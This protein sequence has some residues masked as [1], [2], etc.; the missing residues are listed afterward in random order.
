MLVTATGSAGLLIPQ[1]AVRKSLL[2]QNTDGTN[3]VYVKRESASSISVSAS[4]FDFKIGPGGAVAINSLIDGLKAIQDSYTVIS[5]AGS[6]V[7]AVFETE[8]IGR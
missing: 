6:P 1:N 3:A 2:I 4:N 7:M 5:A 8:D